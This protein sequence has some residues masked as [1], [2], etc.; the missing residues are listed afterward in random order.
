MRRIE[1]KAPVFDKIYKDYLKQVAALDVKD[2]TNLLGIHVDGKTISIPYFNGVYTITPDHIINPEKHR[3]SHAVSVILCKYL[4]LCPEFA[5]QDRQ[6]MTYRDFKDA[7]PYVQGFQNTAEK[8]ISNFFSGRIKDLKSRCRDLGGVP[9]DI[10]ISCDFSIRFQ[11][12]PRIPL[13]LIFNDADEDFPSDTTLLFEKRA[14][15]FLDME[16]LAMTGMYLA[17]QLVQEKS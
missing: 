15:R 3:P 8:P 10:G 1:T 9:H 16:C 12:L 14:A 13:F 6:L 5:D 4:L 2:K 11:A 17:E 7:A